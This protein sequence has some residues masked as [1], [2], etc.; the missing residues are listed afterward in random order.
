MARDEFD[1]SGN[2]FRLE[3]FEGETVLFAPYEYLDEVQT[4]NGTKPA[5]LTDV[6]VLSQGGAVYYDAMIFPLKVMGRLRRTIDK[7]RPV[8]GVIGKG[9]KKAGQNTPWELHSADEDG[10]RA[11]RDF[12]AENPDFSDRLKEAAAGIKAAKEAA[13][14]APV[15]APAQVP[16]ASPVQ[17]A[18]PVAPPM[19]D[20]ADPDDPFAA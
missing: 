16:Q 18:A 6:A 7:G 20:W 2:H 11:A 14:N 9:E 4:V 1:N 17:A 8:L 12:L 19:P 10:V 5:T 13:R 15:Q 3:D